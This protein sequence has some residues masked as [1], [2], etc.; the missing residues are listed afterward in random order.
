MKYSYPASGKL[1]T[2]LSL[3]FYLI[4]HRYRNKGEDYP[5]IR[6][7][8]TIVIFTQSVHLKSNN[9][10]TERHFSRVSKVW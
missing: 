8:K 4:K 3:F 6:S 9:S 10:I 1:R 7:K 5:G 2:S